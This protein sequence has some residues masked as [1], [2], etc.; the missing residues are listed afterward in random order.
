[1]SQGNS[2]C[3]YL[4]QTKMS[5]FFP[6]FKIGGRQNRS[7]LGGLVPVGGRGGRK[8]AWE[9]E[10]CANTVYTYLQKEKWYL[11]KLIQEWGKGNKGECWRGWNQVWYIWYIVRTFVNATLYP[12]PTQLKTKEMKEKDILGYKM[13][14]QIN[15]V[16]IIIE[17]YVT[18]QEEV[19]IRK[20]KLKYSN[21]IENILMKQHR[22]LRVRK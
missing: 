10:Y 16:I 1:M 20:S 21:D 4:K 12:H 19:D 18:I 7:Y 14:I 17:A 15:W 22:E 8:R 9:D 5:F 3:S 2:L 6:I 13:S 11:L